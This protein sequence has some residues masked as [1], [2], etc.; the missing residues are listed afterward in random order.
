MVSVPRDPVVPNLRRYD[1]TLQTYITV[2][3]ITPS[4]KVGLFF[5]Y[6]LIFRA[7]NG[8]MVLP[9]IPWSNRGQ[10]YTG[11]RLRLRHSEDH[12]PTCLGQSLTWKKSTDL[13]ST[14]SGHGF[15]KGHG[16]LSFVTFV[17]LFVHSA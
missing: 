13:D 8:L 11:T 2:F 16:S 1:W 5:L 14:I 17:T 6:G 3:P 9:W 7:T 15:Q 10:R 12:E 4:E